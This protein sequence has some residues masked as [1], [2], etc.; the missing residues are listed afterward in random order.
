M[1]KFASGSYDSTGDGDTAT[2][3][4]EQAGQQARQAPQHPTMQQRALCIQVLLVTS[5]VSRGPPGPPDLKVPL[6][7]ES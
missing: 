4:L 3:E 5:H 6:H 2:T 7:F 1:P